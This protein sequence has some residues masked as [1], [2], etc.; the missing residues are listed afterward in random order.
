MRSSDFDL[1][2]N[3]LEY[4]AVNSAVLALDVWILRGLLAMI[5]EQLHHSPGTIKV[6]TSS[7]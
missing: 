4:D 1:G 5:A 3:H 6:C 7:L 2:C